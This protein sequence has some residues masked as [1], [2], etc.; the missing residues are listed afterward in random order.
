[1]AI[2]NY[3]NKILFLMI[4][5]YLVYVGD[6]SRRLEFRLLTEIRFITFSNVVLR[7]DSENRC[8]GTHRQLVHPQRYSQRWYVHPHFFTFFHVTAAARPGLGGLPERRRW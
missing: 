6:A 8:F 3:Y 2:D 1:M 4:D 5:S 7:G